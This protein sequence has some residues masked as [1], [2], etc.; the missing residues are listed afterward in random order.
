MDAQNQFMCTLPHR[1]KEKQERE[2]LEGERKRIKEKEERKMKK[3][4]TGK[5]EGKTLLEGVKE[6]EGFFA[7]V[8]KDIWG[9]EKTGE[10]NT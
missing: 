7:P 6:I 2:E 3:K 9:M 10:Q 1:K 5:R 8:W 4:E